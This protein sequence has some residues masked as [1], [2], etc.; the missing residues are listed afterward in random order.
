MTWKLIIPILMFPVIYLLTGFALTLI[1]PRVNGT[2]SLNFDRLRSGDTAAVEPAA[3]KQFTARDGQAISYAHYPAATDLKVILLHGSGYHGSY[4]APLG[5]YLARQGAAEVFVLNIRGHLGSGD[6]RGDI[7][8]VGQLEEDIVDLIAM[9]KRDDPDANI[10]IGGHS[11]GGALAI[12]FAAGQHG[13]QA[14]GYFALAP[15]LGPDA[16][17][18]VQS[19]WAHISLPRIIGLTMLNFVGIHWLDGLETIRFNLPEAYRNGSE[20]LG[21]SWRLMKNLALNRDYA[22]DIAGLPKTSLVLVGRNDEAMDADKFPIVF[23]DL[24]DNVE[25]VDNHDHFSLVLDEPTFK[26]V[27][28]WLRALD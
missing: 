4:L 5:D 2:D 26:R 3:I 10:V 12:R 25:L 22:P 24:Q 17:T 15:F 9:I 11:S 21:Y 14:H 20:T 13:S 1:A 16:P 18:M 7:E 19:G 23:K 27:E 6:R 8:H 28:I